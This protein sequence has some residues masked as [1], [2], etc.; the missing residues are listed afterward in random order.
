MDLFQAFLRGKRSTLFAETLLRRAVLTII[1]ALASTLL[2]SLPPDVELPKG[3]FTLWVKN[4]SPKLNKSHC[5]LIFVIMYSLTFQSIPWLTDYGV[6]NISYPLG[7][8]MSILL[9]KPG[10]GCFSETNGQPHTSLG[11]PIPRQWWKSVNPWFVYEPADC[12]LCRQEYP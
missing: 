1:W 7:N 11:T 12:M 8:I 5:S 10:I 6:R 2:C 3:I 9:C 4:M